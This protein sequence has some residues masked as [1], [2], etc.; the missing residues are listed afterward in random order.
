MCYKWLS[1]DLTFHSS[2]GHQLE[3]EVEQVGPNFY[4]THAHAVVIRKSGPRLEM[5]F[6]N[7]AHFSAQNHLL[8][9]LFF[10]YAHVGSEWNH[11][12]VI[13]TLYSVSQ[14]DGRT[15]R[16]HSRHHAAQSGLRCDV[17]RKGASR[18]DSQRA[19]APA[20]CR[21]QHEITFK[22]LP[23]RGP[24]S[25]RMWPQHKTGQTLKLHSTASAFIFSFKISAFAS[26]T[27]DKCPQM[28]TVERLFTG[29]SLYAHILL[30]MA[31]A[32]ADRCTP[33]RSPFLSLSLSPTTLHAHAL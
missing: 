33:A 15:Q 19:P 6:L 29:D 27:S 4:P 23:H 12:N 24:R 26:K 32:A 18:T 31:S 8:F 22:V 16:H 20:S 1:A 10:K 13:I 28:W 17:R 30:N 2:R 9:K 5:F 3:V 11:L 21:I 7:V 25:H 14:C